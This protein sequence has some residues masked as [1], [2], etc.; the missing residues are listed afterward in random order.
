MNL[1]DKPL[2][3][4]QEAQN[5]IQQIRT[6]IASNPDFI[7]EIREKNC[8]ISLE[9]KDANSTFSFAVQKSE[10]TSNG[11]IL[12]TFKKKPRS[13]MDL[14][15]YSGT[16]SSDKIISQFN[17]W[18]GIIKGYEKITL[19]Y[20]EIF[21]KKNQE[22]FYQEFEI[23]DEDA[24]K[25]PFSPQQQLYINEYVKIIQAVLEKNNDKYDTE[26]L[27]KYAEIIR[28]QLPISTKKQVLKSISK[29][30]AK[31]QKKGLDLLKEVWSEAKKEIIKRVIE[32]SFEGIPK[33]ITDLLS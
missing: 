20:D 12:F 5:L 4:L 3:E 1:K 23:L 24:D 17:N 29:L 32:G 30:L 18:V 33:L 10:V 11:Q 9:D 7:Q 21:E 25:N 2:G 22:Y 6:T 27:I 31:V 14:S 16:F 28:E 19:T 26:E 15:E 8:L 13:N